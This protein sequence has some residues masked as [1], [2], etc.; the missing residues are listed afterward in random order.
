MKILNNIQ[1]QYELS[2]MISHCISLHGV[3]QALRNGVPQLFL[4]TPLDFLLIGLTPARLIITPAVCKH[5]WAQ[6]SPFCGRS[7]PNSKTPP[8]RIDFAVR[9]NNRIGCSSHIRRSYSTV[10]YTEIS[11]WKRQQHRNLPNSGVG[12][13]QAAGQLDEISNDTEAGVTF[14]FPIGICTREG[15][16]H[17]PVFSVA[18]I[19][20]PSHWADSSQLGVNRHMIHATNLNYRQAAYVYSS[21][22][23]DILFAEPHTSTFRTAYISPCQ[24]WV[25]ETSPS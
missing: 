11:N 9:W 23:D 25:P 8:L 15:C 2:G 6:N 18:G 19:E 17:W 5:H 14:I 22:L 24:L 4:R 16:S 21:L 10:S 20:Q 3:C 7:K 1:V 13:G 12:G